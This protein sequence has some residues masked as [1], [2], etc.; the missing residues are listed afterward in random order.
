MKRLLLIISLFPMILFGQE[1][2]FMGLDL[3]SNLDNFCNGLEK[4]GLKKVVDRFEEKEFIGKF[5]TYDSCRIYVTATEVSKKIKRV[6]VVFNA[7]KDRIKR[8]KIFDELI[9][10]YSNKYKD[11][12]K[13]VDQDSKNNLLNIT[14]YII[15]TDK[16]SIK[17]NK[18][19][20]GLFLDTSSL[21]ILYDN[22]LEIDNKETNPNKYSEDI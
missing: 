1:I 16:V 18:F 14:S 3:N 6:E 8:D 12:L 20:P 10:Q 9:Q 15:S 4:K 7:K 19:G 22:L 13:K 5:A 11:K 21:N 2:K 17:I